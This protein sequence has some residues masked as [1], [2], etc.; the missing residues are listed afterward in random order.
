M[1]VLDRERGSPSRFCGEFL[2]GEARG[3][4]DALR[5]RQAIEAVQPIAVR[6]LAMHSPRGRTFQMPLD[7]GG[8]GLSRRELDAAL[9]RAV[10]AGGADY[11]EGAGVTAVEGSP[12]EGFHISVGSERIRARAVVGAWGKRSALDRTLDRPF[13]RRASPYVGVKMQYRRPAVDDVVRLFLFPGGYCGFINLDGDRGAVAVLAHAE[14]LRAAGGKPESLIAWIRSVNPALD[15]RIGD[16]EPIPDSV[17]AIAQ[18]PLTPK[19]SVSGGVFLTGDGAG[20]IAPFLGL[21]V[22]NALASGIDAADAIA[23]WLDGEREFQ[24]AAR[25]YSARQR[26]RLGLVQRGSFAISWLLCRSGLAEPV[27]QLLENVPLA[28]RAIYHASRRRASSAEGL[29]GAEAGT[30]VRGW[31]SVSRSSVLEE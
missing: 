6:R 27:L 12:A 21:G 15:R 9:R 28:G 4:L 22:T 31:R 14:V 23:S 24:S 7:G 30:A 3:S 19:E 8:Y 1:V 10:E 18:T 17:R 29:G 25:H 16:A 5:V 20:M 13:L 11:R 26:E 2:S